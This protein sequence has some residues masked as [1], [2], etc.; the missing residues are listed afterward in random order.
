MAGPF[1]RWDTR[2]QKK[3]MARAGAGKVKVRYRPIDDAR[4]RARVL[5][6]WAASI[7]AT[8]AERRRDHP[9]DPRD[10][11][12]IA[13]DVLAYLVEH[14]HIGKRGDIYVLREIR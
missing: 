3:E 9:E 2:Q 13:R 14:G 1:R 5:A 10:D 8:V 12:E 7:R 4:L 11:R 6:S